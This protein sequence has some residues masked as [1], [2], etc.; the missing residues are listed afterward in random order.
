M[1]I[2]HEKGSD[3]EGRLKHNFG[4]ARPE[5]YRKAVRLMEMADRFSLPVVSLV[6]EPGFMI[7]SEAER[8]GTI[9]YGAAAIFAAKN[10]TGLLEIPRPSVNVTPK[11]RGLPG[12]FLLGGLFGLAGSASPGFVADDPKQPLAAAR[13]GE[14]YG[15][16]PTPE[17]LI[18]QL[19]YLEHSALAVTDS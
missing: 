17:G 18:Q 4:M 13:H 12:A 19:I 8:A 11:W 10:L 5:G 16:R 3:T 7:G 2:G 9:R 15:L 14:P 1:V 6:D